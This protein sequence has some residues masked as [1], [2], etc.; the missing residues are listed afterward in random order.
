[1][2]WV[3]KNECGTNPFLFI[4]KKIQTFYFFFF[5]FDGINFNRFLKP[6]MEVLG[7]LT[8]RTGISIGYGNC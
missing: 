3:C 4:K 1:M 6:S 7:Y 5:V 8:H 2:E